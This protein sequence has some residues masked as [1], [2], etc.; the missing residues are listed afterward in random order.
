VPRL[1]ISASLRSHLD[2]RN[3]DVGAYQPPHLFHR[4]PPRKLDLVPRDDDPWLVTLYRKGMC[5]WDAG[6][7]V[8]K[9]TGETLEAAILAAMGHGDVRGAISRLT[10]AL[11]SL[12]GV[13]RG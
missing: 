10:A 5:S 4:Q 3:L 9:A 6:A 7:I 1:R 11:D 12:T 2:A 8:G 13:L